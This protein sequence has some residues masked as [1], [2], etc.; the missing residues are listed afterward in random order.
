M[1]SNGK[2]QYSA[3]FK[4]RVVVEALK[5]E[6]SGMEAQVARAY[7]VHPVTVTKW[8]KQ[9][10]ERG[11]EVFSGKEELREYERKIADLER[12]LGHKEVEIALL[13]NFLGGR[14]R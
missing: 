2:R 9:F 6:G 8:K 12:M 1:K 13:Q 5:A 11:A 7:G 10:L 4:F 3:E 14:S